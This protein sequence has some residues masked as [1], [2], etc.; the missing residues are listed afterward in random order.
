MTFARARQARRSSHRAPGS[1]SLEPRWTPQKF[2]LLQLLYFVSH[3][4]S[5]THRD[6]LSTV[7]PLSTHCP[8]TVHS[9]S[10]HCP[11]TV[12]CPLSKKQPRAP[13]TRWLSTT[14]IDRLSVLHLRHTANDQHAASAPTNARRTQHSEPRIQDSARRHNGLVNA[15]MQVALLALFDTNHAQQTSA[16]LQ[17]HHILQ[18]PGPV[19]STTSPLDSECHLGPTSSRRAYHPALGWS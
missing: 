2:S 1:R 6:D 5:I 4:R 15:R 11:L 16:A 14:L 8:L 3:V 18:G 10:T 7:H 12:Q 19:R 9:L 13:P 17:R